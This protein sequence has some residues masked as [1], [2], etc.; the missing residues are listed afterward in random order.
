VSWKRD[1]TPTAKDL[2]RPSTARACVRERR[3]RRPRLAGRSEFEGAVRAGRQQQPIARAGRTY[4]AVWRSSSL[5]LLVASVR[6]AEKGTRW[7]ARAQRQR[8]ND[9]S[10]TVQ[11]VQD[12]AAA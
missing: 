7:M 2:N 12:S 5:L 3:R 6:P 1:D 4:T 10:T 8:A 11:C 9:E